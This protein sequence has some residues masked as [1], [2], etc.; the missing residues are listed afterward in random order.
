[1]VLGKSDELTSRNL[2]ILKAPRVL[3]VIRRQIV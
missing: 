2:K 3:A 1:M